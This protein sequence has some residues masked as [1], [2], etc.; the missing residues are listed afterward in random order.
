MLSKLEKRTLKQNEAAELRTILEKERKEAA[1]L[2][3]IVA[4]IIIGI[5]IAAVISLLTDL[6][7][8]N[9]DQD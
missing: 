3:D 5:L 1:T 8:E 6:I 4:V 9:D 7:S 2:G